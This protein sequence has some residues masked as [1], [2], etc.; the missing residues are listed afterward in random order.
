MLPEQPFVI[1]KGVPSLIQKI[2]H[3]VIDRPVRPTF[4]QDLKVF[5]PCHK[6]NICAFNSFKGRRLESYRSKRTGWEYTIN[7]FITCTTKNVVYMLHILCVNLGGK[8]TSLTTSYVWWNALGGT[9]CDVTV[10]LGHCC[11]ICYDNM[12]AFIIDHVRA[13]FILK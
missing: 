4:F 11:S 5:F 12:L 7:S 1:F 3:N 6:C 10:L 2:A 9:R 13:F 8:K